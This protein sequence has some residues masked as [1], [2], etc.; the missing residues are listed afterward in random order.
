MKRLW[1]DSLAVAVLAA[2]ALLP[3]SQ[4]LAQIRIG[5]TLSTTGPA[6]AIGLPSKNVALMW[7]KEIAGQKIETFILDDGSTSNGAVLNAKKLTSE[8]NVDVIVGPNTT[9]N[10]LAVTDIAFETKTPMVTLAA[11]GQHRAANG[12]EEALGLQDAPK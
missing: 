1:V 9:P 5:L 4:A 8:D 7:P 3:T 6:A 12:R 10:A 11:S 2:G